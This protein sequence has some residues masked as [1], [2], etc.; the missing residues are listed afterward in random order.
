MTAWRRPRKE[1]II[2]EL[3]YWREILLVFPPRKAEALRN[4][5]SLLDELLGL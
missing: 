1:T 5:D 4:I 3:K 2:A